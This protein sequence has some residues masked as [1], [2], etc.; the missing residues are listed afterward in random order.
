MLVIEPPRERQEAMPIEK[1][2]SLPH[3][4]ESTAG[5]NAT[6]MEKQ[7]CSGE[8]VNSAHSGRQI[9]QWKRANQEHFS[10]WLPL[11]RRTS[12]GKF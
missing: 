7:R 3:R 9:S 8:T 6:G 10:I 4:V 11:R 2:L 5:D 12:S 1:G